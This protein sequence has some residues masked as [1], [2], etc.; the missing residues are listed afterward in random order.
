ME[1]YEERVDGRDFDEMRE[2]EIR[3][4]PLDKADGSAFFRIGKTKV[5][6][7]VYGPTT[8]H[9]KHL[10]EPDRAILRTHYS[11]GSFSVPDRAR[12][13]PSR[14]DKELSYKIRQA[15]ESSL[16]LE[17]FPGTVI[18][19]YVYVLEADAGTRCA[20]TTAVSL[21]LANAGLE[22]KGLVTSVAAG[23]VKD[24]V[25]LDLNKE[26]EDMSLVADIPVA[27]LA[28]EDKITLLQMDGEID[29]KMLKEAIELGKEGCERVLE[30][31]K[32]A[33]KEHYQEIR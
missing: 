24:K 25:V 15:L 17:D 16:V 7:G 22:M 28:N 5:L 19:A 18:D 31:S 27:Y 23:R 26:E 10:R 30:K 6:A 11:L 4:A 9:P 29:K 12:L 13:G 2:I 14:R 33:L 1:K 20:C 8:L 3:I 21:A 32:K